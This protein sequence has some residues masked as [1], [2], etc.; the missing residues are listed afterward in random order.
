MET[1]DRPL[2]RTRAWFVFFLVWMTGLA[3]G[4]TALLAAYDAGDGLA[5]RAWIVALMCFYLSLCNSL[6]PLPT[7]WI[8]LLAAKPE[9]ALIEQPALRVLAVAGI[10]T[11]GTVIANLNEYHVLAY[12]FRRK[13]GARIRRTQLYGWAARWFERSPFGILTLVAFVPIPVDAVRWLAIL[14]GYSRWRYALAYFVGRGPRYVLFAAGTVL[15][16]LG[17]WDILWIQLG[18]V[19][20]AVGSRFWYRWWQRSGFRRVDSRV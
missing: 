14:R 13:L 5:L 9:Y 19:G 11:L 4:A 20:V 18:L 10:A 17:E 16:Q 12:F 3:L 8:V 2:R 7:A 15:L 1:L 6:L